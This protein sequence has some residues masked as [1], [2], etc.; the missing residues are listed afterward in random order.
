MQTI[1][2]IGGGAG[3]LELA[4]RLGD[5]LGK[6]DR[7]KIVLIDRYATHFWKPLL[8]TVAS[9]KLDPRL[10]QIEYSAQAAE[11]GFHFVCGEVTS[12]DRATHAIEVAPYRLD[13]GAEALP[14]RTIRYDK[15]VLAFGAVT[16]FFNIPG[17]AEHALLAGQDRQSQRPWRQLL[18][19]YAGHERGGSFAARQHDSVPGEDQLQRHHREGG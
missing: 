7:A 8:H 6:R 19:D 1:V 10:H 13:D 18:R 17:A 14:K 16:N 2:I 3:G 11:H 5:S 12:V 9:G 4:T 15:L